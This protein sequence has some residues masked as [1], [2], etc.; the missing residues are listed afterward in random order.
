M[1]WLVSVVV[2]CV[3][4]LLPLVTAFSEADAQAAIVLRRKATDSKEKI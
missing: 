1:D 3:V 4:E 2:V